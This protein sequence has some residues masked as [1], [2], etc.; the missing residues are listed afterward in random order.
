MFPDFMDDNDI[1]LILKICIQRHRSSTNQ[2][3][4]KDHYRCRTWA[5]GSQQTGN[6]ACTGNST[7]TLN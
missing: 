3:Q 7:S 6:W 1:D 4:M 2:K 5:E